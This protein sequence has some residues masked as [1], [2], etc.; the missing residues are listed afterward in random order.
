MLLSDA[1]IWSDA[2]VDCSL[3]SYKCLIIEGLRAVERQR[4]EIPKQN[5]N[6]AQNYNSNID[7]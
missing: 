1:F 4:G 2:L 6:C 7:L 5:K 3:R